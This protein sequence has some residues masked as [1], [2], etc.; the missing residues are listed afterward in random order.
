MPGCR[1]AGFSGPDDSAPARACALLVGEQ[2]EGLLRTPCTAN[3]LGEHGDSEVWSGPSI[4]SRVFRARFRAEQAGRPVTRLVK[5]QIDEKV[6]RAADHIR[7][8]KGATYFGVAASP[9]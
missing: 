7:E 3:V 9:R 5:Q 4:Q 8:G 2:R 1:L 6:R